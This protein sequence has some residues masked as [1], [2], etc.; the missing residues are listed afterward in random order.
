MRSVVGLEDARHPLVL[1]RELLVHLLAGQD[2]RLERFERATGLEPKDL[3]VGVPDH[4]VSVVHRW[5]RIDHPGVAQRAVLGNDRAGDVADGHR[6]TLAF[7]LKS[8][9]AFAILADGAVASGHGR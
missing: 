8:P 1:D 3:N 4:R 2:P 9:R 5:D 6:E 7:G